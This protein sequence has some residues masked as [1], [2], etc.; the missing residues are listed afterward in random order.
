MNQLYQKY[1][2]KCPQQS[3]G[4]GSS[5]HCNIVATDNWP[6]KDK[7]Y[8]TKSLVGYWHQKEK[9][10]VFL[11]NRSFIVPLNCVF[12]LEVLVDSQNG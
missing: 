6:W 8:G 10:N 12:R 3:T 1:C 4:T 11:P 9:K 2:K 7:I 5:V